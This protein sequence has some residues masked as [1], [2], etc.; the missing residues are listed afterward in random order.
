M[1][2][3]VDSI[4]NSNYKISRTKFNRQENIAFTSKP[5]EQN[6]KTNNN[7]FDIDIAAKN[8]G[9]GLL[10][11]ITA[12][13]KHPIAALG[14]I[15]ATAAACALV[16]VL[17]PILAVGFGAVGIYELGKSGYNIAKNLK[18]GEYD[19]AEQNFKGLGQ[20]TINTVLSALGIK[21]SAR[22]VKEAK[23]LEGLNAKAL[24]GAQKEAISVDIKNGSYL[25]AVKEILSL[26]TKKGIKAITY[27]FKPSVIK[28][29]ANEIIGM[30]KGTKTETTETQVTHE[31]FANTVEGRRRAAMSDEEIMNEL[32]KLYDEAFEEYGI[33]KN[34]RP[35]LNLTEGNITN[36]GG[37]NSASHTI[38]I[39]KT[40]FREGSFNP[41]NTIKH[42]ATHAT[43]ALIRESLSQ[44]SIETLTK[45]YLLGKIKNGDNNTVIYDSFFG[46]TSTM[47]PP[48]M[49]T[50]MKDAFAQLV[51]DKLYQKGTLNS[52]EELSAVVEPLVRN[53]P[54]FVSQYANETEAITMLAQYAKSHQLRYLINTQGTRINLTPTQITELKNIN[55][56]G[57]PVESFKNSLECIDGNASN[58]T[59]TAK[60]GL[61]G[62][63][64][65][66]QFGAEEVLAQQRGNEFA[67]KHYEQELEALRAQTGYSKEHEAFLLAQIKNA[68][69]TIDY[70]TKGLEYYKL[71]IESQNHPEN[72]E[73][74]QQ[75]AKMSKELEQLSKDIKIKTTYNLQTQKSEVVIPLEKEVLV[76]KRVKPNLEIYVPQ[77]TPVTANILAEEYQKQQ[78][79]QK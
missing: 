73:L 6:D 38:N 3:S 9:K 20:G 53:N 68:K 29:R 39:N 17:S 40:A 36:G 61:G 60:I 26:G 4:S 56:G 5:K 45:E 79:K 43:E 30:I 77:T 52:V 51:Q 75:V 49:N 47:N 65:Q 37:Y 21:Q 10:S 31:K 19:K 63:F 46:N 1:A 55:I 59:I 71:F 69:A 13:F 48:K 78:V 74:A 57:N 15:G 16:P 66:Y 18:N 34:L 41:A 62:D 24:T 32:L 64:D 58:S 35:K 8:F 44:E 12:I 2:L 33:P 11:P 25:D 42:E 70:K 76:L 28:T 14:L 22:V 7:K 27:Q 67:I 72:T 50:Q 23:M 54:E